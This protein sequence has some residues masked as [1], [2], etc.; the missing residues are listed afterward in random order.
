M[1]WTA[2]CTDFEPGLPA[3]TQPSTWPGRSLAIPNSVA[4]KKAFAPTSS[5]AKAMFT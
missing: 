4:T 2:C 1:C 5:R 3:R